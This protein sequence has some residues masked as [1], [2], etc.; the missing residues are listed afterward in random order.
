MS[1]PTFRIVVP[2]YKRPDDLKSFLEALVPQIRDRSNVFLTVVN[3]ASHSPE[4]EAVLVPHRDHVDYKVSPENG[5]P[6]AARKFGTEGATEDYLV[7]TDD[8]CIPP[9]HW[10]AQMIALAEL[11]PT[12]DVIAGKISFAET[13]GTNFV[14][15]YYQNLVD[16]SGAS[17]SHYGI[18]TVPTPCAIIRRRAFEQAGGF[19]PEFR[20]GEDSMLTYA[21]FNSGATFMFDDAWLT[22]HKSE[23]SI[24][25]E[26]KRWF[27]YGRSCAHYAIQTQDW[28][29]V[30]TFTD[31]RLISRLRSLHTSW[32][33]TVEAAR[34]AEW[35]WRERAEITFVELGRQ[36]AYQVGFLTGVRFYKNRFG[37]GLPVVPP[38]RERLTGFVFGE[39]TGGEN[40]PRV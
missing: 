24:S 32:Q 7:T 34:E 40:A 15:R 27:G 38:F 6:G 18:L 21:L 22:S 28:R 4:Y 23:N 11:N 14:E 36:V 20:V 26:L 9:P 29:W 39:T 37:R 10:T 30:P 2:T 33:R 5:G 19:D 17:H 35:N 3:D 16:V 31:G 12:I 8:D 13:E 1:G 25:T